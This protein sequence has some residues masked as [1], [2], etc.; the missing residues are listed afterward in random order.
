MG[1]FHRIVSA[2]GVCAFSGVAAGAAVKIHRFDTSYNLL[3]AGADGMAILN[4]VSGQD[5]T[6][7]QIAV[8]GFAPL[9]NY[10]FV[11][12]SPNH[13]MTPGGGMVTD[14]HGN[15][16]VHLNIPGGIATVECPFFED[17]NY[18]DAD[19]VFREAG[20]QSPI[21]AVAWNPN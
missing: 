8:T 14:E 16:T 5:E 11:L 1:R 18:S 19:I 3:P 6:I 15:A 4:Y 9:T 13:C 2:L 20:D 21:A 17:G 10:T 7:V 12:D